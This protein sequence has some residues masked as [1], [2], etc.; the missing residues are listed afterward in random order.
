MVREVALTRL[1]RTPECE[2][3]PKIA[4]AGDEAEPAKPN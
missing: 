4:V 2:V 1:P 3:D